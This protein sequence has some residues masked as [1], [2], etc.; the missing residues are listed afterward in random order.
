[1]FLREDLRHNVVGNESLFVQQSKN[2]LSKGLI[3]RSDIN[4][5][6]PCEYVTPP[7]AIG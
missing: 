1:M 3:N 7:V 6:E 5:R 4:L 2:P